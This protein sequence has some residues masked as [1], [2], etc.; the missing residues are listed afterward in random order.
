MR[1]HAG[2]KLQHEG[3]VTTQMQLPYSY[4]RMYQM[5]VYRVNAT[6]VRM[7]GRWEGRVREV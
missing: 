1:D 3:N 5:N 2:D 4:V 6:V 7:A